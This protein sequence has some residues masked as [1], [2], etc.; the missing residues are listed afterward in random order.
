MGIT[1][2]LTSIQRLATT[3]ITGALRSTATDMLDLHANVLPVE[4]LLHCICHRAA[5]CLVTLP[6]SHPLAPVFCMRAKRFIKSHHSPLHEL[7]FIFD[8]SPDSVETLSPA[9][10]PHLGNSPDL[11]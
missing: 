11:R 5:V 9:P 2:R 10:G 3:T 1:R 8:I 6:T 7:A 4:L